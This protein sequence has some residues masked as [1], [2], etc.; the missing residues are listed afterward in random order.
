MSPS[1][2]VK[3]QIIGGKIY[4]RCK[5]KTLLGDVNKLFVFKGLLTMPSNILPLHLNQTFT[6]IIWSFTEA[7]GDGIE[8]RLLFKIFSAVLTYLLTYLSVFLYFSTTAS[9]KISWK[10]SEQLLTQKLCKTLKYC[11]ELTSVNSWPV[12]KTTKKSS[13]KALNYQLYIY[14][15][16]LV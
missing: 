12:Q 13:G 15:Y 5:G 10:S 8:S 7:E 16:Q 2:S 6:P 3:I 9:L 11:Y 14:Y 1:P 4:L